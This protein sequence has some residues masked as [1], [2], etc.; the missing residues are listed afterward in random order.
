[1]L[2]NSR[3][4]ELATRCMTN[5]TAIATSIIVEVQQLYLHMMSV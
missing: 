2:V 5:N 3:G 1:M 4:I